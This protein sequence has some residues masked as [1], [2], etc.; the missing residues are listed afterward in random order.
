M[1][2]KLRRGQ[3]RPR[4]NFSG[5]LFQQQIRSVHRHFESSWPCLR[6][7]RAPPRAFSYVWV[8]D[9]ER[10]LLGGGPRP[11]SQERTMRNTALVTVV[12]A[13]LA[14]AVPA[15]ANW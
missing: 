10:P 2:V 4:R 6:M 15:S 9:A 8:G 12:L 13:S 14:A 3:H 5:T 1:N 11:N 7:H